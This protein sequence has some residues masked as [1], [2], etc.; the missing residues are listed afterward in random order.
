MVPSTS[1]EE[2]ACC[3]DDPNGMAGNV[4][5]VPCINFVDDRKHQKIPISVKRTKKRPLRLFLVQDCGFESTASSS[6][7]V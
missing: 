7:E 6:K 3:V 4:L 1:A 5:N 2:N